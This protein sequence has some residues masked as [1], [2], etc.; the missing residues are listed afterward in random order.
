M[1]LLVRDEADIVADNIEF[2]L[3]QGVDF[4]IVTDNGSQDGTADIVSQYERAGMVKLLHQPEQNYAQSTWVTHMALMA[5]ERYGA[6]WI[7]NNDADEFWWPR[8]GDLKSELSGK[9]QGVFQCLRQNMMYPY[10]A[11][12]SEPWHQRMTVTAREPILRPP[13]QE[14]PGDQL[15]DPLYYYRLMPKVF[16]SAE[17]LTEVHMGNH[18]VSHDGEVTQYD[19]E[20]CI[21]HFPVRSREHMRSKAVNGGES[22][23]RNT[24][25]P[26]GIIQH[27]RSWYAEYSQHGEIDRIL[28]QV[29][30]DA[31]QMRDD[32]AAGRLIEDTTISDFLSD[33][34]PGA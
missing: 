7:L 27:W 33:L 20:T 28:A 18:S 34:L 6:D 12:T 26:I 32:M 9:S 24:E 11:E 4:V 19:S 2:H 30:P 1:T 8:H 23:A 31:E 5:R 13:A 16:S 15:P 10:D 17:G 14:V 3:A 22:L 29:L 25:L 21:Y